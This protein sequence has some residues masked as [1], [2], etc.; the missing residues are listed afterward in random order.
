MV[1]VTLPP[2]LELI[3]LL[4]MSVKL[5][6]AQY[7]NVDWIIHIQGVHNLNTVNSNMTEKTFTKLSMAYT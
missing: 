2:L 6:M 5:P 3:S 1:E 7:Y 4:S